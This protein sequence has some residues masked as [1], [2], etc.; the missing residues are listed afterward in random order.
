MKKSRVAI[1]VVGAL[2]AGLTLGGIGI[3]SA[4]S[5]QAQTPPGY[6]GMMAG[7]NS[8]V[9]ALS[10]LTGLSVPEIMALHAQ[11]A[12][13]ATIATDNGVDPAAVIDQMLA[14]RQATLDA[15]VAAGAMT[16]EQVQAIIDHLRAAA[17]A[18]LDAVPHMGAR[19]SGS[20]TFT[21]G[22]NMMT[23]A[24][25]GPHA[26]YGMGTTNAPRTRHMTPVTP[27]PAGPATNAP[28]TA[29]VAPGTPMHQ[30]TGTTQT[31]VAPHMS[32]GTTGGMMGGT[33][34]MGGPRH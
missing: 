25:V 13:F 2:I 1:L 19:A 24:T 18:M 11:G 17:H 8:P 28:V 30:A 32:A 9:A 23:S 4:A 7:T 33:G 5:R 10:S 29:P 27:A 6:A 14:A 15:R 31:T 34:T 3:A 20:A 12:S 22:P 26:R 21:P 16:A